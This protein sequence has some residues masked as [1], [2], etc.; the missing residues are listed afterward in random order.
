MAMGTGITKDDLL[1]SVLLFAALHEKP[2]F[3]ARDC[4]GWLQ[5]QAIYLHEEQT[6]ELL[7][8]LVDQSRIRQI[9]PGVYAQGRVN[10]S[11]PLQHRLWQEDGSQ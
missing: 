9:G 7:S 11:V 10:G 1:D 8:E 6:D 2:T 5:T 3:S 4:T